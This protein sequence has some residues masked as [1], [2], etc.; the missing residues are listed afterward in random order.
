M[1]GPYKIMSLFGTRAEALK[2]APVI[3]QLQAAPD[4]WPSTV[5]TTAQRQNQPQLRQAL[6]RLAITSD[7]NLDV[8]GGP[9]YDLVE[10]I[11]KLL[12][13]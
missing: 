1:Q 3:E 2:L 7:F 8:A 12:Q 9:E 13:T 10:Q 6:D 5:V 4:T 11:S